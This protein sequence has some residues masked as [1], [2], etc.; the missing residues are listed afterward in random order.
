[1]YKFQIRNVNDEGFQTIARFLNNPD[2]DSMDFIITMIKDTFTFWNQIG[3]VNF[4][5][6]NF[7]IDFDNYSFQLSYKKGKVVRHEYFKYRIY[8]TTVK[9]DSD[10][11]LL[12]SLKLRKELS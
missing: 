9:K 1:M 3:K 8:K 11:R 5:I 6:N 7:E 2:H 12:N 10:F 4:V